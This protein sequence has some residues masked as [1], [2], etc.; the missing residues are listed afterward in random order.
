MDHDS[1]LNAVADAVIVAHAVI[2]KNGTPDM[3]RLSRTRLLAIGKEIARRS[4]LSNELN[5]LGRD[6]ALQSE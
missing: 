3:K 1:D 2:E 6:D 5:E 4:K